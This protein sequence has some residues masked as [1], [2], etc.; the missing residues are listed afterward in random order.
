VSI[1]LISQASSEHSICWAISPD[2][3]SAAQ[4]AVENEFELEISLGRVDPL[5]IDRGQSVIAVVGEGMRERPG[6]AARLFGG[7]ARVGI[8][9]RAVAQGSSEL[10]ISL[11]VAG[12]DEVVA[13][14]AIH[15]TF[16][17]PTARR[18]RLVLLGSGKV[19]SELLEQTRSLIPH[20]LRDRDIDLR[21]VAIANSRRLLTDAQGIA[22]DGWRD[23]LVDAPAGGPRE[24]LD[25]LRTGSDQTLVVDATASDSIGDHYNAMISA[26]YSIVAANKK[27]FCRAYEEFTAWSQAARRRRSALRFEATVGAGLPVLS[28]LS[29]QLEAG[30]SFTRVVGVLSGSLSFLCEALRSGRRFSEAVQEADRLGYL[31]PNPWDDLSGEDARRKICILARVAGFALEPE[32]VQLEPFVEG[33]EWSRL[34]PADLWKRLPEVDEDFARRQQ[35]AERDGLR[36]RYVVSFDGVEACARLRAVGP[37]HPC[38]DTIGP[39]SLFALTT[40]LYPDT[41]LVVR[42]PGAG[43][44]VTASGMLVDIL[45]ILESLPGRDDAPRPAPDLQ[46]AA[47]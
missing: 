13:L 32:D 45:R 37:Q 46:E 10:N 15:S 21:W 6:L 3:T 11:V 25:W 26:G 41:P 33:P 44:A 35:E 24:L 34:E 16:F 36:W 5:I 30:D 2:D 42:G 9:V 20:L 14:R 18:V 17:A 4:Q 1:I 47:S 31:E 23:R 43:P 8:N 27:P 39:E 40:R 22:L 38:F 29:A 12:E 28:T 7:L 19:G